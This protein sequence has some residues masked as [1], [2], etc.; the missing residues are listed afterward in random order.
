MASVSGTDRLDRPAALLFATAGYLTVAPDYLGLGTGPG[1]HPYVHT[2][3]EASASVDAIRAA[4]RFAARSGQRLTGEVMVSGFS[5]GGHAAMA[6][7][8]AMGQEPTLRLRALAPISGPYDLSGTEI[9]ALFDGRVDPMIGAFYLAYWTLSSDRLYGLFDT[10]SQVFRAPYD[11][12]LPPLFDGA[13]SEPEIIPALP[14]SPD[15]LVTPE[16]RARLLRPDDALR[17][18]M[19]ENSATCQWRPRVPVRLYASSADREVPVDNTRKCATELRLRG[20]KVTVT[21][22]G[23]VGHMTSPI[24]ALPGIV[25]WFRHLTS[26]TD[27]G[28]LGSSEPFSSWVPSGFGGRQDEDGLH[29]RGCLNGVAR[30]RRHLA[31]PAREGQ[32]HTAV[33]GAVQAALRVP[34]ILAAIVLSWERPA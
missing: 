26:T 23:D 21:D 14:A 28:R 6:L 27:R 32:T 16:Y 22:L 19:D 13:H 5:Q 33:R 2:E 11:R 30:C 31:A 8:Q 17:R 9:P 7:G 34:G 1:R 12:T 3:T 20:A 15:L 29:D 18:A 10:P 4:H 25:D 24:I